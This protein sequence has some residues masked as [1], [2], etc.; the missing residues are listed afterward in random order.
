MEPHVMTTPFHHEIMNA[1]Q[2]AMILSCLSRGPIWRSRR[3]IVSETGIKPASVG[4]ILWALRR[5]RL[6]IRDGGLVAKK[7]RG[8]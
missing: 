1:P 8:G 7:T 6:I 5:A 4:V 2:A 3:D